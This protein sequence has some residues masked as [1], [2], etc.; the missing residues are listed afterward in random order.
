MSLNVLESLKPQL[1][2]AVDFM[3]QHEPL[4]NKISKKIG[5][6]I[7]FAFNRIGKG[8]SFIQVNIMPGVLKSFNHFKDIGQNVFT[9]MSQVINKHKPTF[10]KL[11]NMCYDIGAFLKSGIDAA[12]P[13]INWLIVEGI[14]KVIDII[15]G[16]IGKAME[17]YEYIKNNWDDW[18][19]YKTKKIIK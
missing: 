14:P 19:W 2:K 10:M 12:R 13:V 7:G 5:D 8:I 6:G 17:F 18:N 1:K 4:F 16:L 11:R 15:F 3:K 9:K